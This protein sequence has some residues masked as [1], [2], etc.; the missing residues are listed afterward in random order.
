MGSCIPVYSLPF[1]LLVPHVIFTLVI[2]LS[3]LLRSGLV[4]VGSCLSSGILF[5]LYSLPHRGFPVWIPAGAFLCSLHALPVYVWVLSGYSS[6]LPPPKNIHVRLIG[7]S[8]IDPLQSISHLPALCLYPMVFQSY[9]FFTC[10]FLFVWISCTF[11]LV[12]FDN[13]F[14]IH[15][16]ST[17]SQ[18]VFTW[19]HHVFDHESQQNEVSWIPEKIEF[20]FFHQ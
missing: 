17:P 9:C 16:S 1:R 11:S 12:L 10:F 6:F 13:V 18:P 14:L 15:F 8:K 20:F 4:F 5:E 3:S 7:D 2:W 19:V